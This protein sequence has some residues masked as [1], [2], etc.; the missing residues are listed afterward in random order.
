[1]HEIKSF[2]IFQTAKVVAVL[3]AVM[4]AI[5]GVIA[6]SRFSA[7]GPSATSTHS[8]CAGGHA[9]LWARSSASS[10]IAIS[11]WVYNLIAHTSAASHSI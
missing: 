3:Y 4:F 10:A 6:I 7:N 5:F 9:D 2:K 1:M 8:D 11:C